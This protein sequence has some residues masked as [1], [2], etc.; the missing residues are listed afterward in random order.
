MGRVGDQAGLGVEDRAGEVQAFL[1]VHRV[2]GVL[3]AVA[4]LLGDGH[5]EVVEDLQHDRIGLG[6]DGAALGTRLDA[7]QHDVVL[8]GQLGLPAGFDDRGLVG[9]GD[10]GRASDL[11]A[12][13]QRLAH[14][15][16][17]RARRR[18]CT[19]GP[20]GWAPARRRGSAPPRRRPRARRRR[21]LRP[22]W[23][24]PPAPGR[25]SG[26]NSAGG[27]PPRSPG[28]PAPACRTALRARCRCPG[29]SGAGDAARK[30]RPRP[31]AGAAVRPR[32][33]RPA[34]PAHRPASASARRP[35]P[36]RR[37]SGACRSGRPGPCH[38]PTA[39]HPAGARTPWSCPGRRPPGRRA[40][41]R[42]RQ[43]WSART[44]SRRRA[45]PKCA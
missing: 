19:C 26:R 11:V 22:K 15:A 12:A 40:A 31:R 5:E 10:D 37:F 7:A 36:A 21:W 13:R 16:A 35:A 24:R 42:R 43:R 17:R 32:P 27:R 30:C 34:R 18:R 41:R 4:H 45:A 1:D 20:G 9:L 44:R 29:T 8:P 33:V 6:A 38:R 28:A 25:A 3:Q 2:R 23:S 39:R 14:R